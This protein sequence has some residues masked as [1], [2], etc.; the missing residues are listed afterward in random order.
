MYSSVEPRLSLNLPN[1][2]ETC[3]TIFTRPPP[4]FLLEEGLAYETMCTVEGMTRTTVVPQGHTHHQRELPSQ[5]LTCCPAEEVV[6]SVP[7]GLGVANEKEE[8][9]VAIGTERGWA[10]VV[11][12]D[13]VACVYVC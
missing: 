9:L 5:L 13:W 1:S 12:D 7:S 8:E 6:E 2:T 4:P 11:G 3:C 10:V